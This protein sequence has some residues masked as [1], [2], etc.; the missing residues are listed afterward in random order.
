MTNPLGPWWQA[1]LR[2]TSA[3]LR[4]VAAGGPIEP[5]P[6]GALQPSLQRQQQIALSLQYRQL[7][8]AGERLAFDDVG[9]NVCSSTGEDGILL[10]IFSLVGMG[11]RCCVDI[12][13]AGLE[14]SNV[15]NL[16][17]HHGFEGLLLDADDQGLQRAEAFYRTHVETRL[18]PPR[19]VAARVTAENVDALIE[20]HGLADELDLLCI[21]I[22]GVDYWI[23]KALTAAQPRAVVVEYQDILG[24]ERSWT[25]PYRPDFSVGDFEVNATHYNYAGASLTAMVRLGRDKG[26]R[27]V[28]CNRG[29]YN[30]FFLRDDVGLESF[31][32]VSVESCFRYSWNRYG[33]QERFPLVADLEWVEV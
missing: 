22:D 32:A 11:R 24:P 8:R 21:D 4:G 9:F 29:G 10:Y 17:L 26:Y 15:A 19:C 18:F 28:G 30:A 5:P 1:A 7:A 3:R 25:V 14:G 13:A 2:R 6:A 20:E 31:P 33:M 27:L 23:W 16:L 12:G